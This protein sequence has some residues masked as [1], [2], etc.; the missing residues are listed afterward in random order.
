VAVETSLSSL[1]G[2]DVVDLPG[3]T[4]LPGLVDAHVHL[5]FD[6]SSEPVAALSARD[7]N[8]MAQTRATGSR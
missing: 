2:A 5:A 1:P 4:L 6:A 8:S 3:S 7:E